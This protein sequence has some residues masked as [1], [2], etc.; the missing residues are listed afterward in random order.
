MRAADPLAGI[1]RGEAGT[2]PR[3]PR[4]AAGGISVDRSL[5]RVSRGPALAGVVT[6]TF[7]LLTGCSGDQAR[8]TA[9]ASATAASARGCLPA[10]DPAASVHGGFG[11]GQTQVT[12]VDHSRPTGAAPDRNLAG[13]PDRTIPVVVSYPI[14]PAADAA[15]AAP[16]IAGAAS[17]P[18]RF[19]LVVLSHGVTSD[20]TVAANVI[21]APL[22]RQGYVVAT[23]TFPLSS[24]PGG[25]IFDLPNQPADV[26]FVITSLSAWSTT[27]GT[28]LAGHLQASCLAI[29]GHSL[30]AATTLAAAYLSCCRDPRVK[31]VVSMAGVIAAF[32]G[33]FAGNPPTPLLILHGD[34]DQTVPLDKSAEMF[35]TLRG[36]R[37]FLTLRGAGH[38][39]MFFEQAGQ[40]LDQSVTAFLDAYLK[41]DFSALHALPGD[42]RRSGVATYQAAS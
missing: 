35:R 4:D 14:I 5:G 26:S 39:T 25:T 10:G 38:S 9:T 31:A 28:P 13:K 11:I 33:T 3:V 23:P 2:P 32:K 19:P 17:A 21:A 7:V 20:G 40:T 29:A 37:Y 34:Q 24:G 18:G 1:G 30:G 22:V 12:F 16:A 36:P 6:L 42:V 8:P 41:G 27:A 15:P